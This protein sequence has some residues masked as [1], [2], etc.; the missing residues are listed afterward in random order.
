MYVY[1]YI[2]IIYI[3][4]YIYLIYLTYLVDIFSILNTEYLERFNVIM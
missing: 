1:M 4:V 2:Y 3:Y